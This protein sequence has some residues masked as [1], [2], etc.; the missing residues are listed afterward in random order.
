LAV[1]DTEVRAGL[2]QAL[3]LTLARLKRSDGA[4]AEL[5]RASE[6][7]PERAR[8]TF[9]YAV[10]LHSG[11]QTGNSM[12]VLEQNLGRHPSDRDTL[13]VLISFHRAA[14]HIDSALKIRA[15]TGSDHS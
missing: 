13:M 2:H 9:V 10:A 4:I 7:E 1:A 15:A 3:G 5:R 11:G 12:T 6:L 14:G 8:Y